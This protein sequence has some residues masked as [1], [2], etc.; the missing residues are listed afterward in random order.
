MGSGSLLLDA[1]MVAVSAWF[2]SLVVYR[3]RRPAELSGTRP[4][5]TIFPKYE[6]SA[7]LSPSLC[8]ADDTIAAV[9]SRL[10]AQDFQEAARE[11]ARV[12][13]SRGNWFGDFSIRRV[14]L[15]LEMLLPA[16]PIATLRM[17]YG[18]FAIFDTGD[19]W[20]LCHA[21]REKL[22]TDKTGTAESA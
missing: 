21:V 20:S 13:F 18:V 10:E 12:V 4:A 11:D 7:E 16:K 17:S 15:K 5:L 2:V 19:L 3:L 8:G 6:F 9:A 1:V 14:R 22:A